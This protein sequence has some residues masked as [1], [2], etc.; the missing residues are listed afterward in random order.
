MA[1]AADG[2]G[3]EDV[4][5]VLAAW[6]ATQVAARIAG[7]DPHDA[8]RVRVSVHSMG[9]CSTDEPVADLVALGLIS[10]PG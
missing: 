1:A 4:A 6:T 10:E 8:D 9:T 2:A 3:A 5:T 7:L